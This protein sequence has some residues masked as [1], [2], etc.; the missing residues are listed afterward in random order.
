MV[1]HLHQLSKAYPNLLENINDSTFFQDRAILAPKNAI[2]DVINNYILDLI[3]GEEKTYLSYDSPHY[4]KSGVDKP[5]DVH[6]TEFLNTIVAS[7]IP[8]H[9]IRL[10]VGV[11]VMLL[12]N[13]DQN[14][15]LCNG[16]RLVITR[17]GKYVLE[18]KVIT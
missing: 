11:P 17:M 14:L 6:T 7:G 8:N 9:K 4:A 13:I 10:K 2:V 1:I 3:P 15:G 16:T 12:R 5:D 18:A